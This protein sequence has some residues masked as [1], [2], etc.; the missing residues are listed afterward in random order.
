MGKKVL[1]A[2]FA[3]GLLTGFAEDQAVCR[4]ENRGG[5][6]QEKVIEGTIFVPPSGPKEK[7]TLERD[8]VELY[9]GSATKPT[10]RWKLTPG[11]AR[12]DGDILTVEVD[13]KGLAASKGHAYPSGRLPIDLS[14]FRYDMGGVFLVIMSEFP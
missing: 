10:G 11:M 9:A 7:Q 13:E 14:G 3:V 2:A 1:A 5:G 8:K 12:I 6:P 4:A